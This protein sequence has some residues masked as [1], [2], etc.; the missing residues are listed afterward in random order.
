[1]IVFSD[2]H[3]KESTEALCFEVLAE[4]KRQALEDPDKRVVF[5]GDW[6]QLR[7]QVNVRLL[8]RV[9]AELHNWAETDIRVDLVPGNHDQVTVN[10]VNALEVLAEPGINVWTEP[11]V[12][13]DGLGFCPYRKDATA[14][15]EALKV[16]ASGAK[17]KVVFAHF[18]LRGSEMNGGRKDAE[19]LELPWRAES[20]G[21]YPLVILGH[22]H[23]HQWGPGHVYVG[24]PYQQTWGEAGNTP[25]VFQLRGTKWKHVPLTIG[26]KHYIVRWDVEQSPAPPPPPTARVAD[27]VRLDISAPYS[28]LA[29]PDLL[30]AV[31]ASGYE[32]AAVNVL[33][34]DVVREHKFAVVGG[35]SLGAA[36]E[37]FVL[38][39]CSPGESADKRIA[40]LKRWA[41]EEVG[42]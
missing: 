4:V 40:F 31:A 23:R 36:A 5:C 39:R 41:A 20:E 6:W 33:P 42:R 38:E 26:P 11:G 35:E 37:R 16:A 25:G 17:I 12:T 13:A 15:L 9:K 29:N 1:M 2:L 8:N 3:L 30:K 32:G 19:G 18:G 21:H 27:R 24:S 10:G 7:Y 22:Y 34:R 14:Q 28:A